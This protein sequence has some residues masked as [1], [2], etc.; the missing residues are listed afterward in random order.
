MGKD[1]RKVEKIRIRK[2]KIVNKFIASH[3]LVERVMEF[4]V[5]YSDCSSSDVH[6]PKKK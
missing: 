5:K 4:K 3:I 1:K 2:S 6:K